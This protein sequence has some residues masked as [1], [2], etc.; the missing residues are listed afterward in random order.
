MQEEEIEKTCEKCG[1]QNAKHTL[2][3]TISRLPRVLVVHYKRFQLEPGSD[4]QY[5]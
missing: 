5:R 3:Q 4:G 1:Q 2:Q